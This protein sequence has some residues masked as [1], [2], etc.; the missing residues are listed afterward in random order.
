MSITTV[1]DLERATRIAADF[2]TSVQ[3]EDSDDPFTYCQIPVEFADGIGRADVTWQADAKVWSIDPYIPGNAALTFDQ[4]VALTESLTK[5]AD[6]ARALNQ[7]DPDMIVEL[8]RKTD[9]S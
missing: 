8:S 3:H 2:G 7:P 4:I 5:A 9:T 1:F 6:L